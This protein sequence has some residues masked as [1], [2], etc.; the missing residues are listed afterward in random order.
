MGVPPLERSRE[1][2]SVLSACRAEA[3]VLDV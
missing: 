2:G 1:W 3:L